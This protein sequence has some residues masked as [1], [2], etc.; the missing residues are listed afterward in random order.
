MPMEMILILA[1][2][3]GCIFLA[4]IGI[5]Y[6]VNTWMDRRKIS[7]KV[8]GEDSDKK[9]P[10]KS[11]FL[12]LADHF[13]H[14]FS[15][16]SAEELSGM[17]KKLLIAGYRNRYSAKIV[18]GAKALI[19]MLVPLG[20]FLIKLALN[21]PMKSTLLMAILISAA[22]VGFYAP[23]V[24]LRLRIADRKQK[25]LKGFPDALDLLIVCVEA[26][27]SLDSAITRVGEEL[28]LSNKVLSDELKYLNLELR[29]GK[30]RR[31]ALKN[32]GFRTDL[33]EVISLM[34]LLIQTDRFGTSIA[35]ALRVY[36]E[37]MRTQ[38]YQRAEEMAAKLPVK[39][40]LPLILCI[41]PSLFVVIL[42]PA[43]IQVVRVWGSR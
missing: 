41:F 6:Y 34:T 11:M 18:Y 27:M 16:K 36:S 20:L 26:G 8:S 42:G 31:D 30:S 40:V 33:E 13:G 37:T 2:V 24:F 1:L 32:F 19:C 10:L 15:P 28:K 39:L 43:I 17:K 7:E 38:R 23:D 12:K 3:F 5:S 35:Q 14:F 25:I 9:L 21:I 29:A 22:L 4:A